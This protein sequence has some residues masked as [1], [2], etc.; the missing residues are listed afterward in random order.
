MASVWARQ[1]LQHKQ[2]L[3]R[4]S[5]GSGHPITASAYSMEHQVSNHRVQLAS[6]CAR[7]SLAS[8]NGSQAAG[9]SMQDW[10]MHPNG[11]PS[12]FAACT[13]DMASLYNTRASTLQI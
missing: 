8:G 9:V 1:L 12:G 2:V 11:A 6:Y 10:V 4:L 7:L 3:I 13:A 5:V